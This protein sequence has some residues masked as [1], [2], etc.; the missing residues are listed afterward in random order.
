METESTPPPATAVIK[1][2]RAEIA[3]NRSKMA[4]QRAEIAR[5]AEVIA[6]LEIEKAHIVVD[7]RKS[8]ADL[9]ARNPHRQKETE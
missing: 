8:R 1:A 2:L 6:R 4:K 9:L 7:L 3:R 5:M